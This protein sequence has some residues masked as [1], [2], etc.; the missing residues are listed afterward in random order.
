MVL[1]MVTQSLPPEAGLSPT[2]SNISAKLK[3]H[4]HQDSEVISSQ[5]QSSQGKKVKDGQQNGLEGKGC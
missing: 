5:S 3:Y 4:T 1:P 2:G